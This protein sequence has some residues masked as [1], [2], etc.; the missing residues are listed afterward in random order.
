M[1]YLALAIPA[2]ALVVVAIGLRFRPGRRRSRSAR[3]DLFRR[4]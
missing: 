2:V 1:G 3:I 4:N